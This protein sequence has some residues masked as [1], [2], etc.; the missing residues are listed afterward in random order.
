M[1]FKDTYNLLKYLITKNTLSFYIE[2]YR[3]FPCLKIN[4]NLDETLEKHLEER[5]T[6]FIY[7][8]L[9]QQ[10][11][12]KFEGTGI[13]EK[14]KKGELLFSFD[15]N[16]TAFPTHDFV[17]SEDNK[18][19]VYSLLS[20]LYNCL[21]TNDMLNNPPDDDFEYEAE[22]ESIPIDIN[23]KICNG[24]I[25]KHQVKVLN[26]EEIKE[27]DDYD[28][29]EIITSLYDFIKN[30]RSG[31]CD[32]SYSEGDNMEVG[33]DAF[34][35]QLGICDFGKTELYIKDYFSDGIEYELN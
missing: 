7:N 20:C 10:S 23:F 34:Y 16:N 1:I 13:V 11:Q 19:F 32:F 35:Q 12:F 22:F 15:V 21:K 2:E 28:K 25:I 18:N 4:G 24:K 14:N 8:D 33:F 6:S 17:S 26:I 9:T 5:I 29:I 27:L 3:G 31:V 30:D